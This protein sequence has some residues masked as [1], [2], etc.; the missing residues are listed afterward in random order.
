LGLHR[1]FQE[2]YFD[3]N[4]KPTENNIGI[5]LIQYEYDKSGNF[6]RMRKYNLDGKEIE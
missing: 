4:Y 3:K 5:H 6:S 2:A 1:G